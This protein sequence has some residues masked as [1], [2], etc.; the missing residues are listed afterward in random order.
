VKLADVKIGE[1]YLTKIGEELARVVVVDRRL[2]PTRKGYR[3]TFRVR[4]EGEREL[5]PKSRTAAALRPARG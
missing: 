4:R 1:V 3:T 2:E 5:L